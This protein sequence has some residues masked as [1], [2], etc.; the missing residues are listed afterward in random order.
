M[1]HYEYIM[2]AL[3]RKFAI[4]EMTLLKICVSEKSKMRIS[5]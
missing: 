3:L 4:T 5:H 1:I 2:N